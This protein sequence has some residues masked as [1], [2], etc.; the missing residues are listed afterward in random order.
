MVV[1]YVAA[2]VNIPSGEHAILSIFSGEFGSTRGV[3]P[4][5]DQGSFAVSGPTEFLSG[6]GLVNIVYGPGEDIVV[7]AFRS[8]GVGDNIGQLV[9]S[10]TGFTV[11]LT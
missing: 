5:T 2:T 6:G 3:L 1:T 10:M 8:T 9:A 4:L 11:P 7:H